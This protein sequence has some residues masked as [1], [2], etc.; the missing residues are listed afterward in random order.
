MVMKL[1]TW[2]IAAI[3]VVAPNAASAQVM[4]DDTFPENARITFEELHAKL[5]P[6]FNDPRSAQYRDMGYMEGSAAGERSSTMR[7]PCSTLE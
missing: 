6:F 2:L 3:L 1:G 7:A 4:L 5:S